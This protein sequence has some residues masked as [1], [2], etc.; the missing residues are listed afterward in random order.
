MFFTKRPELVPQF[1]IFWRPAKVLGPTLID[2]AVLRFWGQ[3]TVLQGRSGLVNSK[4][5][6]ITV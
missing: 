3:N 5:H 6:N 1:P 4:Y 2:K